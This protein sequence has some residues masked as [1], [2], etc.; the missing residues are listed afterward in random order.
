MYNIDPPENINSTWSHLKCCISA[1]KQLSIF[2]NKIPSRFFPDIEFREFNSDII[3]YKGKLDPF[4]IDEFN[5]GRFANPKE[6]PTN[7][8]CQYYYFYIYNKDKFYYNLIDLVKDINWKEKC[9]IIYM[10]FRESERNNWCNY[11]DRLYMKI[12]E[13]YFKLYY[14][15][16]AEPYLTKVL[17]YNKIYY[18]PT[19]LL[20]KIHFFYSKRLKM[21]VLDP[22]KII[23]HHY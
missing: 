10:K 1:R 20:Q 15:H 21:I 16:L 9:P 6:F 2:T 12:L 14:P 19:E 13:P 23:E 22:S 17:L 11:D 18:Y 3:I 4:F 7:K 8:L 5:E